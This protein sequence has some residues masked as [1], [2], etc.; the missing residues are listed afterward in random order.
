MKGRQ[1]PD[2]RWTDTSCDEAE[3]H[4][5]RNHVDRT[6]RSPRSHRRCHAGRVRRAPPCTHARASALPGQRGSP[7]PRR[8]DAHLPCDRP[9]S[10]HRWGC[11]SPGHA[12]ELPARL[13]GA[14]AGADP[15]AD[16]VRRGLL[17]RSPRCHRLVRQC[18]RCQILA[19]VRQ[20]PVRRRPRARRDRVRR[21]GDAR[22]L[23]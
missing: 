12:L 19:S 17:R 6:D 1:W 21:N 23:P 16:H 20:A 22:P 14:A 10:D 5:Y 3:V 9:Q 18:H 4:E 8:G 13:R 15:V 2:A 7:Q 11:P